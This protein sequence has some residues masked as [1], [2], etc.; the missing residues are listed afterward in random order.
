MLTLGISP[1]PNDT[2]AFHHMLRS[3]T[4]YSVTLEDV[5]ELNHG[6]HQISKISVAGFGHLRQDY[7]LLRSG[8]AAGFG[9][10][11]LVVACS[12]RPIGGR[13]AIPG[14]RTTAALLLR[15]LGD[16]ETVAMRFDLIEGAVL[17]GEV[18]CG[19]LIHEGR[20]TFD[21]KGLIKLCD[22]GEVW[23]TQMHVPIPLG[24]IAIR[25]D[26]GEDI[27]KQVDR[28]IRASIL[29][30]MNHPQEST[31]FVKIHAQEMASDVVRRHI[32]LYVNDYTL[33]LDEVAVLRLLEFGE[34]QG[35]F[36]SSPLPVFAY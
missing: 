33:D 19:V 29:H 8:G 16:F 5:E 28:E 2:F 14:H 17:R 25:R 3:N 4:E 18:D 13:I 12:D 6:R 11:P 15:L 35:L 24:A 22:L 26:L 7:A 30:A 9:V 21:Q 23:E 10:G 20:F 1:C 34:E 32:E 27:S 36:P 31:E